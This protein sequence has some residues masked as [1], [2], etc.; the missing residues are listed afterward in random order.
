MRTK[1]HVTA[2]LTTRQRLA[3]RRERK[4][5]RK[6]LAALLAGFLMAVLAPT[7][8]VAQHAVGSLYFLNPKNGW[9]A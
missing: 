6:P 9:Q 8:A 4:W 2:F 3:Q 7:A 1:T 5:S